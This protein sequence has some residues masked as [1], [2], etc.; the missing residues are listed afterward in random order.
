MNIPKVSVL[1]ITFNQ[2]N[3]I[4]NAIEGILIQK[5]NFSIELV[6]GDDSS[7]DLTKSIC[8]EYELI[9][10]DIIKILPS[11]K[12]LGAILN[13]KKT[14]DACNGKFV[15]ICEGDDYWIDPNK[16]QKQVDY[17]ESNPDFALIHSNK[18]VLIGDKFYED[19]QLYEQHGYLIEDLLISNNISTL[20]VLVRAD[21]LKESTRYVLI[22]A[23]IRKWTMLDYPIWLHIALN[24]K[25]EFL[26]ETMGVYRFSSESLSHSLDHRKAL[27]FEKSTIDVKE[28][29]YK[30][31][32]RMNP[33]INKRFKLRF[34]ENIFHLRKRLILDYG[35]I[36]K[37]EILYLVKTNPVVYLRIICRKF[38]SRNYKTKYNWRSV[39]I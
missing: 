3:S 7:T 37:S 27:S 38:I 24:H 17:L 33:N 4:R 35:L 2:E 26:N 16:L 12:N 10:P 32:M 6:I 23:N 22:N 21:I 36:A 1:L 20:T 11:G 9:R 15:A 39:N 34:K 31:Y 8:H 25:I 28:F 13:F 30:E 14:L 29:F 19:Q 5:T 18:K